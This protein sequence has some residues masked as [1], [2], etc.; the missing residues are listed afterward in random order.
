[1]KVTLPISQGFY[2]SDSLPISNQRCVNFYPNLPQTST[3]TDANLFGTPGIKE[4]TPEISNVTC[5]GLHVLAGIAYYVI[6]QQ[7]YR[8]NRVVV[9]GDESFNLEALGEIEGNARVYMADNGTQLCI[10]AIPEALV[11][12]GRSYIF[13]EGPETLTEITD[14]GFDGPASSVVY[15]DGYFSFHKSDGKKFFNS[16]LNDGLGPYDPLDFSTAEADPDQIRAQI[17]H[18]NQLYILGSETI[19]IFRNIGRS[20]S[21]FIPI[22]GALL[23]VGIVAPQSLQKFAQ[24]FAFVGAGVNETP[25]VWLVNGLQKTKISTTAIDNELSKLTEEE[26]QSIFGWEYA[27]AGGFFYGITL[28]DTC[29]VYDSVNQRWHERRSAFLDRQD[30]YRVSHMTQAY[31]RIL[32]GDLQDGRTGELDRDE[33]LEYGRLIKAF[34]TSRPF[35]DQGNARFVSSIEAVVDNGVG[36]ANDINVE[37]GSTLLGDPLTGTGGADP[38]ITMS[39]SDDGGRTFIGER[40]RSM[41]KAGEYRRRPIWYKNGRLSRSRVLRFEISAPV[42][43]TIVKVEADIG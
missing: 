24:S 15:V 11:T 27:E 13:T 3:V 18:R 22:Q 25:A 4:V 23:D 2:V 30:Q 7:L 6:G 37:V 39:Y 36:L 28:P 5:R 10:V 42:K 1:M 20:P 34:V 41:G 29:F 14:A 17:V 40:S 19:Q 38:K 12:A 16:P 33:Y 32:V 31:G 21:P 43:R 35:D 9:A 26:Q 8:L